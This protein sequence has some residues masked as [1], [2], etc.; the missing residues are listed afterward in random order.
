[1][2]PC[3][4][5]QGLKKKKKG[6]NLW[7]I[8][9]GN[10]LPGQGWLHTSVR[11][12]MMKHQYSCHPLFPGLNCAAHKQ[13]ENAVSLHQLLLISLQINLANTY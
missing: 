11:P 8:L 1:M 3:W 7:H 9:S 10:T 4:K 12:S 6:K 13:Q 5:S 2:D